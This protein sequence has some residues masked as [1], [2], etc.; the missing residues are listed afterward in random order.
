MPVLA[1][2]EPTVRRDHA[3]SATEYPHMRADSP[4]ASVLLRPDIQVARRKH[5]VHQVA[6]LVLDACP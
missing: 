2:T 3:S 5:F 6:M 1:R 4:D